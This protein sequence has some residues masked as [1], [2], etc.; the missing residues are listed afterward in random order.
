LALP[1]PSVGADRRDGNTKSLSIA[2]QAERHRL[3]LCFNR[4]E[5]CSRG[6]YRFCK[7]IFVVDGVELAD[8]ATADATEGDKEAPCFSLQAVAG[9][10]MTDTMQLAVAVGA[11]SL[12][13]LLDSGSPH[14][15]R[16]MIANGERITCVGIIRDAPL[17]IDG[18]SFPADL[19]VMPLV[20]YDTV[21]GTKWLDALGPIVWDLASKRMS[22][23]RASRTI[24]WAGVPT[25]AG[26]AVRTMAAGE[27]LL[28]ALLDTFTGIF[29]MPAGLPPQH[30]RDHRI[31]LK[32]DAQPVAIH[33]YRYL[34]THK[35]ELERQ[36]ASM[37]KQGI[38]HRSDSPFSS[39]VLLV[40]KPDGSWRFCVDYQTLNAVTI[41][42]AFPI[43]VVDELLNELHGA[44]FFS[45]IDLRSGYHQV[46]MRPADV[47][48]TEFLV[49]AFGLC[50]T[51]ATFQALM[52]DVLRSF[53][54]HFV[55][56]FFD[57]ILIY[58]KTWADH[59]RHLRAVLDELCRHQLF[60]KR[61]KCSF[62]A[63]SVATSTTSSQ[64]REWP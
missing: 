9:V 26:P 30:A 23:Q 58:S 1:T 31:L 53:I 38:I 56:V 33:P 28:E 52:N 19:Y 42:D 49:M 43:L 59:L 64:Q 27:P 32:P 17:L 57:D 11:A 40:K 35:D 45:K 60:V 2:E 3:G 14:N 10:P 62:G 51:L 20:G 25:T 34:A 7:Q 18:V 5:K 22:F 41:K 8:A 21:L 4:D 39:S 12:V 50:N 47:H 15:F 44:K 63:S 46:L 36:C 48:K 55:L 61:T 54:R 6:H 24:S 13:A 37:I 29:A 16:T